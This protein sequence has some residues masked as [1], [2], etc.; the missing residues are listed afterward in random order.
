[1]K[2]FFNRLLTKI[3]LMDTTTRVILVIFILLSFVTAFLAYNFARNFTSGM[4]ILNLPGAP[5]VSQ[6]QPDSNGTIPIPQTKLEQ[7]TAE[8]WDG[9]S[10]VTILILGVDF[11]D[12]Q[13]NETP[14]SDTMILLT[15]DPVI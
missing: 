1:M 13:K 12:W 2:Q 5:A 15:L 14:R 11:R 8:P 3:K 6:S 4:T 10:R 7:S 9:V